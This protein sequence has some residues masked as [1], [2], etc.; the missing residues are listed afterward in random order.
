MVVM[1]L[2]DEFYVREKIHKLLTR[3]VLEISNIVMYS[4]GEKALENL[5]ID[6]PD[7]ILADINMPRLNGLDFIKQAKDLSPKTKF[8]II[9]GYDSFG[10]VQKAIKYGVKDY[11]LKPIDEKEL[12]S[13][14][15][16]LI[17]DLKKEKIKETLF[18]QRGKMAKQYFLKLLLFKNSD[19][20]TNYIKSSLF[21]F[22]SPLCFCDDFVVCSAMIDNQEDL[23]IKE[24]DKANDNLSKTVSKILDEDLYEFCFD[25][26]RRYV[27]I[28][29][30]QICN[31]EKK[32]NQII[33]VMSH[34]YNLSYSFGVGL[35]VNDI[36]SITL[37]YKESVKILFNRIIGE[38]K[39]VLKENNEKEFDEYYISKKIK[40]SLILGVRK[41]DYSYVK[42]IIDNIFDEIKNLKIRADF[43]KVI[44]IH[45][46]EPCILVLEEREKDKDYLSLYL[47]VYDNA[48]ME[49]DLGRLF[50]YIKEIYRKCCTGINTKEN[51]IHPAVKKVMEYVEDNY[52]NPN[53]SIDEISNEIGI[54][55]NY[56]CTIFKKSL[57]KTINEY[58]TDYRMS[59]ALEL[60]N[61]GTFNI[62]EIAENVGFS[63]VS[64]FTRCFKKKFSVSPSK[65]KIK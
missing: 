19:V 24:I 14:V 51:N 36:S 23:S 8:A 62:S 63:N 39:A 20:E 53:I 3:A 57:D 35:K 46:L 32:L 64:Y 50:D 41:N 47:S 5:L 9:S 28:Y 27:L 42:E 4:N 56:L 21:D 7:I 60:I 52:T 12:C 45:L 2:D 49:N 55:Y 11:L 26:S 29:C 44:S 25:N 22:S 59:K 61:I 6:K 17:S 37:S 43:L 10:Y 54:N 38:K 48:L 16:T 15:G 31:I 33:H 30:G 18:E 1:I 40:D 58:V 65:F 34:K 13:L